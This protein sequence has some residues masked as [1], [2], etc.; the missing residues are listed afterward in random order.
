[1]ESNFFYEVEN[2]ILSHI[3]V[4]KN[5]EYTFFLFNILRFL[6]SVLLAISIFTTTIRDYFHFSG[7]TT[8]DR[9]A[10]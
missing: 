10:S 5:I 6:F 4:W 2:N 7:L 1:M 8:K 9:I 3:I